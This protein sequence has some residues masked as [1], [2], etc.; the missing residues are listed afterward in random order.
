MS[1]REQEVEL[2]LGKEIKEH[3]VEMSRKNDKVIRV[4]LSMRETVM[5]CKLF[6]RQNA[7]KMRKICF[8]VTWKKN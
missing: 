7:H 3:L 1:E 5:I 8:G 6:F 4:K 2:V